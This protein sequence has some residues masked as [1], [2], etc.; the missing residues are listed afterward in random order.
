MKIKQL[1]CLHIYKVTKKE[2][3]NETSSEFVGAW[4]ARYDHYAYHQTCV[5][6]G[7][8]KISKGREMAL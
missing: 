6:C 1:F 3:L 4:I 5:K 2:C 7:K 8:E